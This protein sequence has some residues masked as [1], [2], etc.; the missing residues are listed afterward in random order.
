MP[1]AA[2]PTRTGAR[3]ESRTPRWRQASS[4]ASL[5]S[6]PS[7][8]FVRTSSSASA[9]ASSSWSRRRAIS[10]VE[11]VAGSG[12]RPRSCRRTARP[13]GG[14]G[15]RSPRTPRPL[16]IARWSGAILLPNARPQRVERGGRVGVLAVALVDEEAGRPTGRSAEG[17]GG[18]EAGLD[19]GRGVHDEQ[20][21]VGRGEALDD[22]G[23]EV[24]VAGRVDERDPRRV[25]LER[26][27]G[28]AERLAALLLLGLVVEVGRP[29]VDLAEPLDRAGLEE[30][31]LGERGLAAAGVAG[32]DDAPE[33]GGVDAL[34]R[35]R[36]VVPHDCAAAGTIGGLGLSEAASRGGRRPRSGHASRLY[37]G[38]RCQV[39]PSGPRSSARRA[40]T[41]PSAAPSS[42]RSRARS[43]S[44]RGRAAA[45]RTRTTGSGSPIEK[46]RSVNMPSDNIKR[47]IDK[48]TGG[49]DA[50]QF[51]E[52]VYEGYGP[53]G[54]A[55]LVEAATDNRNRTAA[56]VRSIFTK[57]GGQL[58]GLRRGRLAVRAARPDRG[59]ARRG[60]R[61]RGRARGDRRG[62]RGRRHRRRRD[63]RDLH[64]AGRPRGGPQGA[65]GGRRRRSTR[66]R[67][68]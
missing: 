66:P 12:S 64:V 55:V 40:S 7:R 34:H 60:R 1:F 57:T 58:A 41:T 36:R 56:E 27:D 11:L 38:P 50:E 14:R 6:S 10:S 15:R 42:R 43:A 45:I 5:I 4:S 61:R 35:H 59:R 68:R 26:R 48:A 30:E 29:V 51:E 25:V 67:T 9:A 53:G 65:R 3:I 24:R 52:I 37:S 54:V 13:C 32:Q 21:A 47:T 22:L 28:E 49:G 31:M 19:A 16:P 8:Y 62:R 44:R 33:V 23:H 39:T 46:A 63:D 18:L 2:L 17:D 20:R